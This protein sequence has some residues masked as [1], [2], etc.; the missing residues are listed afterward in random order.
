M[1]EIDEGNCKEPIANARF[2]ERADSI[3]RIVV[4]GL[5]IAGAITHK[6]L[7]GWLFVLVLVAHLLR[8]LLDPRNAGEKEYR[9]FQWL[10][11][12]LVIVGIVALMGTFMGSD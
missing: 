5:F 10:E 7:Y 1:N 11:I 8:I 2:Q 12:I 6:R 9:I 4:V 3:T